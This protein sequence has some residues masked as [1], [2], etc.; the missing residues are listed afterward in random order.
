LEVFDGLNLLAKG[1]R[2]GGLG[3]G[4]QPIP[5]AMRVQISLALKTARLNGLRSRALALV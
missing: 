2:I 5:R 1:N 4:I 3:F